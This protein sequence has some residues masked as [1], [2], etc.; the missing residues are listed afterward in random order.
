VTC[1]ECQRD[2]TPKRPHQRFCSNAC[3]VN[4]Y[5]GS[6]GGLRGA[7]TSVRK[8]KRGVVS[9]VVRFSPLEANN[10]LKLTP[11]DLLEVIAGTLA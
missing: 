4:N 3:R 2:F 1:P 6:D 9:V 10:A 11:G 8:M 5:A 7:V